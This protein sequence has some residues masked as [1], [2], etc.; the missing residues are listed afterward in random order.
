MKYNILLIYQSPFINIDNERALQIK[1][2]FYTKQ[3]HFN[4]IPRKLFKNIYKSTNYQR[5]SKE[6]FNPLSDVYYV[7]IAQYEFKLITKENILS[8]II[9]LKEKVEDIKEQTNRLSVDLYF[10]GYLINNTLFNEMEMTQI[11]INDKK[12][13]IRIPQ[14]T[15]NMITKYVQYFNY[16]IVDT[17]I[18]KQQ[19]INYNLYM[20]NTEIISNKI[21]I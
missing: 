20:I 17:T 12:N 9:E 2:M 4:Y 7:S 14:K 3:L 6:L 13:R 18:Y 11:L 10:I 1:S 21:Y 5:V 8:E 15:E 16:T 19:Q